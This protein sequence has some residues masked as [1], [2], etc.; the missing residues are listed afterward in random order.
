M[1]QPIERVAG[2]RQGKGRLACLAMFMN[3]SIVAPLGSKKDAVVCERKRRTRRFLYLELVYWLNT[4]AFVIFSLDRLATRS[5][6]P[7][8]L[9]TRAPAPRKGKVCIPTTP[10][11]P[12]LTLRTHITALRP[13]PLPSLSLS[14]SQRDSSC[15]LAAL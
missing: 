15:R 3:P 7:L 13:P 9:Y 10:L 1:G 5:L 14:L 2:Y 8:L 6:S 11:L 12:A 4:N